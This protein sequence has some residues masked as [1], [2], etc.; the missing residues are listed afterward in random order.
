MNEKAAGI[1]KDILE[2]IIHYIPFGILEVILVLSVY[3]IRISF[4]KTLLFLVVPLS[5]YAIR[6]HIKKPFGF[7]LMH[8]AVLGVTLL[9][10][11]RNAEHIFHA[12][13]AVVYLFGSISLYMKPDDFVQKKTVYD[14]PVVAL[15]GMVAVEY[16]FAAYM[17]YT[18]LL[19]VMATTAVFIVLLYYTVCYADHYLK[20]FRANRAAARNMPKGKM[21]KEG[22]MMTMVFTITSTLILF[23]SAQASFVDDLFYKILRTIRNAISYL[24]SL[25]P[26]HGAVE[27][28]VEELP[29]ADPEMFMSGLQPEGEPGIL[30][31]LLDQFTKFAAIAMLV[32]IV[33]GFIISIV[34]AYLKAFKREDTVDEIREEIGKEEVEKTKEPKTEEKRGLF[35]FLSAGE[36]IRHIFAKVIQKRIG[37]DKELEINYP[38]N[39]MTARELSQLFGEEKKEPYLALV[40]LY[41]KAR[42]SPEECSGQDVSK[43]KKLAKA[44]V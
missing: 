44:L 29:Q 33:M 14:I 15:I 4:F 17:Q 9:I 43:A 24:S 23:F 3:G 34:A 12:I 32:C 28:T 35:D 7:L 38:V 10:P 30:G 21:L 13:L 18:E 39:A 8:L 31:D 19:P 22:G 42:Y 41:E 40:A 36:R 27:E 11:G 26:E 1:L 6:S 20:F 37:E 16:F 5:Y 25:L 2:I